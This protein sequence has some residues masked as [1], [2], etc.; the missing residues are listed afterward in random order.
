[1]IREVEVFAG[2]FHSAMV[3]TERLGFDLEDWHLRVRTKYRETTM[4]F[5][6]AHRFVIDEMQQELGR[7]AKGIVRWKKARS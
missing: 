6:E 5:A 2:V 3:E 1:M 7:K 4:N